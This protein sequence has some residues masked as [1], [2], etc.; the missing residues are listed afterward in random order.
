MRT[1]KRKLKSWRYKNDWP[2]IREVEKSSKIKFKVDTTTR[3]GRRE[4]KVCHTKQEAEILCEQYL[5]RLRNNGRRAFELS[6]REQEDALSAIQIAQKLGF[7]T[8]TT[9]METLTVYHT[10]VAG[11]VSTTALRE[12]FLTHYKTQVEEGVNSL[13]HLQDLRN[14]TAPLESKFG[15]TN[16]KELNGPLVWGFLQKLQKSEK[17]SRGTLKGYVRV[18]RQFFNFARQKEYI[19]DN[20]LNQP[21]IEFEIREATREKVKPSPAILTPEEAAALLKAA[22]DMQEG[23]MLPIVAVILFCGLRP[24][25]EALKLTWDDF[26]WER[27]CVCI[28]GDRSKSSVSARRVSLCDAIL[29]WLNLSDRSKPFGPTNWKRRW[30]WVRD[31]AGLTKWVPDISRHTFASYRWADH[32]DDRLL[33]MELGHIRPETK[34]HYRQVSPAVNRDWKTFFALTPSIVLS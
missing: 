8:L 22:H 25:S 7:D 12:Q 17:W 11:D 26:D 14:R 30:K 18:W 6:P 1:K 4:Q 32:G 31:N 20:P 15:Q 19:T 23:N 13:R 21:R 5:I 34:E 10:S 16:V 9:A 29:S 2:I 28:G 33:E 27:N 24:E 3:L